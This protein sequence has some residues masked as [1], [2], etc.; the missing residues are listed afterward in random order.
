MYAVVRTGAK[1]Y[2]VKLG[3]T[4]D[5]ERIP[6]NVGDP[7]ELRDVLLFDDGEKVE[8]GRPLLPGITVRGQIVDQH[9]G[10]KLIIFKKI[11]RHGKQ[12]KKGH[13]QSLTKIKITEIAP[14]AASS[15]E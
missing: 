10:E 13:R 9:R 2:Q 12:L 7:V 6:G 8:V 4:L 3:M 5:I 15:A 1:Q 11:R 14:L